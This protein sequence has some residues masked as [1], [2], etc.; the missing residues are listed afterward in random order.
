MALTLALLEGGSLVV[1]TGAMIVLWVHPLL[2]D[3]I[4]VVTF[5]SQAFGI[6]S[7]CIVAFYYNDLYDFRVARN[8]A[9]FA[10]RLVQSF[11]V[12]FILLA[13]FY[14][15]FPE[16]RIA[17]GPFISSFLIIIGLLLPL[18]AVSYSL[19]RSRP[20][21]E[22][23]LIL[24][25]SPLAHKLISEIEAL[26]HVRYRI[27]GIAED[28]A[29]T[30]ESPRYPLL[31]PL[32]H[33]DKIVE[34]CAP[35]R[36]IVAL[37]ERR[38]R[39]PVRQ[40]LDFGARGIVVED[41]VAVH[42]RLAGNLAIESFAPSFL[43]FSPDFRKSRLQLHLRRAMS[44]VVAAIGLLVSAPLMALIAAAIA[45]ESR[46]P[47]FFIQERVGLAGRSF[48]LIKFRTMHLADVRRSEWVRDNTERITRVGKWLRKFRLDEL[49]QFFNVIS[50]DMNLVGPRPHPVSNFRLFVE[51]I[52]YYSIRSMVRP[53]ITGW[54]QVRF[55][56]ANNLDEETEKMRYDLYYIKHMS[57]WL[58]L[59]IL[60]DTVK[61][62]LF[63]RGSTVVP[64]D[65]ANVLEPGP[66]D[67]HAVSALERIK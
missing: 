26:P 60:L 39:L 59:K 5:L 31:G 30:A 35:D 14:A 33:L 41:G 18:R 40:L 36:I 23:V 50:G 29:P 34:E 58:D 62:V 63:G 21:T 7:C 27:V 42:E 67:V 1:A 2:T 24:G 55:G 9:Q 57:L 56:Y 3:W 15:L 19:M 38:G 52:P 49:P 61:I 22:R 25:A 16:T 13:V 44:A 43:V 32:A 47:V 45:A 37:S 12:V 11:G 66:T 46:G 17:E 54:A 64:P 10:S 20:F 28:A 48:K 8:F 51:N 6:S 65:R 4:D 53:G